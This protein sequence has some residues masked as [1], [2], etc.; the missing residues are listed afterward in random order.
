MKLANSEDV[1]II[2]LLLKRKSQRNCE[3]I[4]ENRIFCFRYRRI[5]I[6][7]GSFYTFYTFFI[8]QLFQKNE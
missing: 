4:L 1:L 7:G 5:S 3:I 8:S 6:S 2:F